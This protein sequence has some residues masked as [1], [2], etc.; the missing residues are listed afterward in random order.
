MPRR[1]AADAAIHAVDL[2]IARVGR[3]GAAQR[4]I[5]GATFTIAHGGTLAVMGPTGAGKSSLAAVLAGSDDTS[6]AVIGGDAEV[7]GIGV[8]RPGRAHRLHTYLTGYLPQAAGAALPARLTVGEVIS[9]P[10]TSR[11][12]RVNQRALQ[13]RVATLLDEMMLPLGTAA[14]YPYELSAGMRQRVAFAR[15][16][17][18]QPKVLVADEPFSNMDVEVRRAARDAI[19]RR[20]AEYAMSTLV[21]TNQADVV[22]ELDADVL[23]LRGG[24]TVAYGHGTDDLLWT[25]DGDADHR[26]VAS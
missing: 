14:K 9:E 10:I 15:A 21:V 26:L 11:D 3:G 12:R 19:L 6:L 23:V 2:S 7:E 18:L 5:D 25:P 4:V 13:I 24:H 8:R 16:L 20:R 1:R 17:V 22:R